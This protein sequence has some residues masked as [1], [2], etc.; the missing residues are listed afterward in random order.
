MGHKGLRNALVSALETTRFT[1]CREAEVINTK[2]DVAG[3]AL[4]GGA[5]TLEADIGAPNALEELVS[6][7]LDVEAER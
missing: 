1:I 4:E 5:V 3:P 7:G 2:D 6:E